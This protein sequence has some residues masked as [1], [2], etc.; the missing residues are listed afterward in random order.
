MAKLHLAQEILNM[1]W[2]VGSIYISIDS[3]NPNT[4]FG[5]TWSQ[6][7]GGFIYGTTATSGSKG[8]TGNTGTGTSTGKNNG[9]TG[10]TTLTIDQM[11]KHSHNSNARLQW[12]NDTG[13]GPMFNQGNP[14]NVGVDRGIVYTS[15]AGGGKGHTHTLNNHQH[16]IPYI[17]CYVWKRTA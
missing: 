5:G 9:N 7:T 17:E 13:Y 11:P 14:S 1:M 12:Y 6:I 4:K 8:G 3:T 16:T 10:S 2:P 15:E